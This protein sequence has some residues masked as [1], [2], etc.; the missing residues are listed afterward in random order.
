MKARVYNPNLQQEV[1]V[2]WNFTGLGIPERYQSLEYV[3]YDWTLKA[4]ILR[5]DLYEILEEEKRQSR[6]QNLAE[7]LA[8]YHRLDDGRIRAAALGKASTVTDIAKQI[9]ALKAE[10]KDK[11]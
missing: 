7:Y 11:L 2:D 3:Y 10:Y 6:C 1:L 9:E 8:K 5:P 4:W